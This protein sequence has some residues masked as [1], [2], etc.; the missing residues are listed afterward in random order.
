VSP[1]PGQ[2]GPSRLDMLKVW[3]LDPRSRITMR[4]RLAEVRITRRSLL[5]AGMA[6][7]LLYAALVWQFG[8]RRLDRC[9]SLA[10]RALLGGLPFGRGDASPPAAAAG[11]ASPTPTTGRVVLAPGAAPTSSAATT[12][13]APVVALALLPSTTDAPPATAGAPTSTTTPAT[14]TTEPTTTTSGGTSTTVP[15]PRCKPK[16][17]R[18]CKP[19]EHPK[20]MYW[21]WRWAMAVLERGR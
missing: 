20:P 4:R 12:T 9:T 8:G 10:C 16:K 5:A 6:V 15:Q 18:D 21:W 19:K 17:H 3:L 14:T 7:W 1:K 11:S 13:T 2:E